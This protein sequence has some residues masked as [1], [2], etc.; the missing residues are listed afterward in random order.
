MTRLSPVK[1]KK[2]PFLTEAGPYMKMETF[3]EFTEKSYVGL[4][5]AVENGNDWEVVCGIKS[6]LPGFQLPG[7]FPANTWNAF[8]SYNYTSIIF[9]RFYSRSIQYFVIS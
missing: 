7:R 2:V 5:I 3:Q 8:I 6:V 9:C 1:E 4:W